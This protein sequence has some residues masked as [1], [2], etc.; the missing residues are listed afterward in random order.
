MM[1]FYR[2]AIRLASVLLLLLCVLAAHA[3]QRVLTGKIT[4]AAGTGMP[5]VN[6]IKKGTTV[7]TTT[8]GSGSYS[9]EAA[10][11]DILVISFIGYQTQE[12]KV[13]SQTK[14]NLVLAED[15]ET[16]G[17]VVVIGYGEQKKSDLTGAISSVSGDALRGSVTASFDQALQGRVAGVQ[18]TQNSGQPGGAVS[19]RIRGTT[20]LTQSSEPLYV[21]DGIQVAGNAG[22]ITG[23]DWAGGSGG[24]QGG[25]LNPMSNINPNDIESIEVLK[26]ASAAAIYGSRG[27]NGVIIITTKRGKKGL[28]TLSYNGYVGVQDVYKTF[29]LMDLPTYAQYNNEVAREVST[30]GA[31][32]AFADP[33]ILE[34]GTDWQA[35]V[36]QP[37]PM[38][39]HSLTLSGGKENTSYLVSF[40]YLAQDGIVIGSDF[41]RF[42]GRVNLESKVKDRIT[43]G[44]NTSLARTDDKITQQDGGD[45]VISQAAQMP[46]HIPV[47]NFDGTYAGPTQQNVSSQIGSNPVAQAL[48][49]NNT[50]LGNRVQNNL[51]ADIDIIKGLKF[52]TELSSDYSNSENI[53]F[54]PTYQWGTL[55]NK[56]SQ[57][58][59]RNSQNFSWQWRN[60][61]TYNKSINSHDFTVLAAMEAQKSQWNGFTAYK[62][63]LPNDLPVMNQGEISNIPNTGYKGWSSLLSYFARVNYSYSDRFLL[64]ATIRRDG[65]SR[66]GPENRWG[67]FPSASIGWK[68]SQESFMPESNTISNLKLRLGWGMTGNQEIDNG[69]FVSKLNSLVTQ[70]GSGVRNAGYSNP[71]VQWESTE[72]TNIGLDLGLFSDRVQMTI[73][74]YD[75][76]TDNLLLQMT[77][78]EVFGTNVAGPYANVGTM[79]NRGIEVT[80][81]SIN[82]DKGKLRWS[83]NATVSINRNNVSDISGNPI[84]NKIY[85]Y[86]GFQTAVR[87][88]SGYPVGQFYGYVMEGIFTTKEEIL[89]HAVQIPDDDDPS[90][91]KIERTTGL[92]LGDIKWKD[93]NGDGII[94]ARD[95]TQIGNP[96]PDWTFGFNNNVTYGPFSLDLFFSGS[97]GGD[98]LNYS[99]A[100]NEQMVGNFD[101]QSMTVINRAQTQLIEGGTD[102]NDI[103]QVELIN[104]NTNMPRFDNGTENHNHY[105]STRWIEDATYVRL[106]NIRLAYTLPS[107]L[108]SKA[109]ISRVQV[110]TN[111]QNLLTFTNYSG[112]DPQIGAFNQDPT[113]QNVDMGRYPSPRV[114]TFG[115][116]IDF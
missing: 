7:G 110:Y 55:E 28:S 20:S 56:T 66:F 88:D 101:N 108:V 103:N 62:I 81:N 111:I 116:N 86:S 104:P 71:F 22:A 15:I 41:E 36:F 69:A 38:Q 46:P 34:R 19:I 14:I 97:I 112:L 85:W 49:K 87:T 31:N 91:N 53:A 78:P 67:W 115:L 61:A 70:F 23:F 3:Q 2:S 13:G 11:E 50:V 54:L 16:L 51:Y 57:L 100:R 96:N 80:L 74:A 1:K 35:A 113:M 75:K 64:Q 95:Q 99:R 42:T 90:V 10:D 107:S 26:D 109:K 58:A 79:T 83:T 27:A 21:I 4:D 106:Q 73:E 93:L 29:D 76:K 40:G 84:T 59:Q 63:N 98:I 17:E 77:L 37:A 72:Q 33:S 32:A 30:I 39:S 12:L 5:G 114:Y 6:V 82:V 48:I 9:L 89:A 68:I 52:R 43:I 44:L 24:Q 60:Y 45:G 18:V 92:W 25:A 8:D 105:M 102:I 65:S 47:K 94:D